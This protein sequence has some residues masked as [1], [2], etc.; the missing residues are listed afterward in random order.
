MTAN[1]L[2]Q[3]FDDWEISAAEGAKILCLHSNKLSEYLGDIC[4]IPCAIAFSVEALALMDEQSRTR[5]FAKRLERKA[6]GKD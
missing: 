6:H 5:L 3:Q 1:E 2:K 4:R